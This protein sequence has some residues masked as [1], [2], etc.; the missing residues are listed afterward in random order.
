MCGL[1]GI[2]NHKRSAA[3]GIYIGLLQMEHRGKESAAAVTSSMGRYFWGGDMGKISE[4]HIE[5]L[6]AGLSNE[7]ELTD[8]VGLPG[9]IG[10]GHTRY[11]TTGE[12]TLQ[13]IQPIRGNFRGHDFYLA[14][15]GNLVNTKTLR[16]ISKTLPSFSDS[17]VIADLI[18]LSLRATFEEALEDVLPMLQGAFSL[19]ILFNDKIY[20][21][22]DR[23]GFHPLQV[24]RREDGFVVASES[25]AFDHLRVK[26]LF[27]VSPG[28]M[29]VI[30]KN[31]FKPY[32]WS[33]VRSLRIDIF[34]YIYFLRPD[35]MVHGVEAGTARYNM[36]YSL[37][38]EHPLRAD[39]I[40][41]APDSGNEAALGYYEGMRSMGYDPS[42]RPW[43]LFRPHTGGGGRTFIEPNHEVRERLLRSK[44]NKSAR[45]PNWREARCGS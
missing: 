27:D 43:A 35:S 39:I 3:A 23:F 37:A 19:V 32:T 14:H 11:S 38:Q 45:K 26:T 29:V 33:F 7:N 13:N 34:E 4:A 20:A 5:K 6:I 1:I 17:K 12:S 18:S 24:G 25:C 28:D 10:I 36:G 2:V 30:D 41:S 22:K 15:N 8:S 40:I 42:F 21:I 44:K 16:F 31:G 9:M